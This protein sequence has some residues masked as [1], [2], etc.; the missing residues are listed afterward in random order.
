MKPEDLLH[1]ALVLY[2]LGGYIAAYRYPRHSLE[3][4][5]AK[6]S[7]SPLVRAG[8]WFCPCHASLSYHS[9]LRELAWL[10]LPTVDRG[11]HERVLVLC[12][13]TRRHA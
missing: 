6:R 1:L 8:S 10:V 11:H 7:I 12:W 13:L 3:K 9:Y 5:G 2:V 4:V